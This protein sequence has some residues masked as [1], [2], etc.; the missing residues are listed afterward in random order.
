MTEN[1]SCVPPEKLPLS[2]EERKIPME[3]KNLLLFAYLLGT[4]V[5]TYV[6]MAVDKTNAMR[7]ARRIPE[8]ALLLTAALGGS[9][10]AW[11]GM[12]GLHHKTRHKKFLILVPLFMLAHIALGV[13]LLFFR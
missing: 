8:A 3:T 10:G 12:T 4:N 6:L 1:A 13:W 2:A 7:G 11:L 5:L 9:L